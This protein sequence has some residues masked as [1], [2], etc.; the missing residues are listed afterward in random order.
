MTTEGLLYR[1]FQ[2]ANRTLQT[3]DCTC[4]PLS[5]TKLSNLFIY[6]FIYPVKIPPL[7]YSLLYYL[8]NFFFHLAA[9]IHDFNFSCTVSWLDDWKSD[10][11]KPSNPAIWPEYRYDTNDHSFICSLRSLCP[12]FLMVIILWD[13]T[14]KN[15]R[16]KS[17]Q[18]RLK[19][20]S[21]VS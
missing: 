21:L 3:S 4:T 2:H 7:L 9:L 1:G 10:S 15:F 8:D 17:Y 20:I 6:L 12:L 13:Y 11:S 16:L 19:S 5:R 18:P 14:L